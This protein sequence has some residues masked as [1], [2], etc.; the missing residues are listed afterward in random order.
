MINVD[1]KNLPP[2]KSITRKKAMLDVIYTIAF[3]VF[4]YGGIVFLEA[5]QQF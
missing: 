2:V 4:F 5:Y 1:Y 3:I